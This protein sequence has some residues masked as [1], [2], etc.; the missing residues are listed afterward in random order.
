MD[1]IKSGDIQQ[2]GDALERLRYI[3]TAAKDH[4]LKEGGNTG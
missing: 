1:A 3:R 2:T 4:S